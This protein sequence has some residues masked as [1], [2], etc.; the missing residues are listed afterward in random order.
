MAHNHPHT[1][2]GNLKLAFFLNLGFTVVEFIGGLLTNST[3]ILADAVHDLGDCFALAQ[4]WY[5]ESLAE[6]GA[7]RT[8]TYGYRRFTLLGAI[9]SALLLLISSFYVLSVAI[10]RIIEPESSNAQGMFALA[11]VGVVVNGVAMLRLSKGTNAN[12][13]LVAL[14]LLEDVL[15]W[16]AIL[17]V[18][19]ILMFKDIQILDPILA[20]LITLY[21]LANIVRQLKNIIPVFLQ[22]APSSQDVTEIQKKIGHIEHINGVHHLNLWSLDGEHTVL[23]V[24]LVAEKNL[25]PEEYAQVKNRFRQIVDDFGIF[26]ST[27][28]IELPDESCR[29]E[30]SHF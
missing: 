30:E 3:A 9:I 11:I 18:A 5:F 10:P 2:V 20:I 6:K 24:H 27:L 15:G 28:E 7:N 29:L 16:V 14:H 1:A 23:T 26:H 13:R 4:A 25:T 19:I 17:V 12:V 22:A 8:Y 21:I